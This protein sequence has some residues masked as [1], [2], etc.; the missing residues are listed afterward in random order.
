MLPLTVGIRD[1]VV[2]LVSTLGS[3]GSKRG[4]AWQLAAPHGRADTII[5]PVSEP[6]RDISVCD[7]PKHSPPHHAMVLSAHAQPAQTPPPRG[8]G[9]GVESLRCFCVL[10]LTERAGRSG[11]AD[12]PALEAFFLQVHLAATEAPHQLGGGAL[13]GVHLVVHQRRLLLHLRPW[14][15]EH[16]GLGTTEWPL[17]EGQPHFRGRTCN[18]RYGLQC[19]RGTEGGRGETAA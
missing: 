15:G 13:V 6:L 8:E 19:V 4:A 16:V 10:S 17:N 18:S 7:V 1:G 11:R 9:V 2:H 14:V 12:L 3:R 5:M